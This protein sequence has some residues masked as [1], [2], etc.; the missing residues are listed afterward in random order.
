MA[1]K[2]RVFDKIYLLLGLPWIILMFFTSGEYTVIKTVLLALLSLM[3]FFEIV[4]CKVKINVTQRK[5]VVLFVF[6]CI[7]SLLYGILQGYEFNFVDDFPLIQS[8]VFTPIIVLLL[9]TVFSAYRHRVSYIWQLLK[10]MTLFLVV[11][12]VVKVVFF[13]MGIDFFLL[14]FIQMSSEKMVD[15]L[16]LRVSNEHNLFFL[17]PIFIY[18]LI[19]P[20][21]GYSKT[22]RIV[23]GIIVVFSIIYS[24]L[25]VRKM[26]I[27]GIVFSILFSIV[28]INGRFKIQNLFTGRKIILYIFILCII[29]LFLLLFDEVAKLIGVDDLL[30]FAQE[31]LS[32]NL[33]SDS[34]G[35]EKRTSNSMALIDMWL[36]S[37]IWGHGINSYAGEVA[38]LNKWSYEVIYVAW[39]MQ[40]GIIGI[41]LLFG[42]VLY[43]LK[44]LK[45]M[46]RLTGNNIYYAIMLGFLY[47]VIAGS[48][49]PLVYI[50]WPWTISIIFGNTP[51]KEGTH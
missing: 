24:V 1:A 37:P 51:V 12:D 45:R 18:L 17:T 40:T 16:A 5:Y 13:T 9:S 42:G 22:D 49:N 28:F 41:I 31:T 36:Y 11:L 27:L 8:F 38:G 32:E 7:L 6:F 4:Q 29:P 3:S 43:I 34:H 48:S 46:G 15:E 23:Y 50:L 19:N 21:Q 14:N 30:G 26:L 44:K 25:S 20:N 35:V 10:Y 33:S 47:F 39:L 2:Y